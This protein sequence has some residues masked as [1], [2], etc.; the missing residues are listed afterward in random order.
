MRLALLLTVAAMA[1][2]PVAEGK[3]K[4][5]GHAK[6]RAFDYYVLSLSWAPEYCKTHPNDTQECGA[7]RPGFVLHGLWPQYKGGGY[8]QSCSTS[9]L[10][11]ETLAHAMTVF[12]SQKLA[13][14]EWAKHG[15]CSGLSP[16]EYV[17]AAD[18]AHRSI[19]VP[20]Q[21]QPGSTPKKMPLASITQSFL[22][23]NSTVKAQSLAIACTGPELTEVRVCLAKDLSPVACGRDVHNDCRA[24]PITVLGLQ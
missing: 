21:F 24:S 23:A 2:T 1:V 18:R 8:P 22:D 5:K 10:D 15:T 12:P 11:A 3:T 13:E 19:S 20:Q 9:K 4:H 14:H 16:R 7:D 6:P 17:D